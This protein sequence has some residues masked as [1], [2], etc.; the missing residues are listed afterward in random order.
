MLQD[1]VGG[2]Q[3]QV[4]GK[5]GWINAVPVPSPFVV[6]IGE[7]LEL[8]SDGYLRETVHRVVS[9]KGR[10]RLSVAFFLGARLDATVPV[11]ALPPHL[12]AE[13]P[14]PGRGS[15]SVG[16]RLRASRSACDGRHAPNLIFRQNMSA[17]GRHPRPCISSGSLDFN[18]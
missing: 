8:A 6:N 5:D 11:L 13:A 16:G 10:D 15:S 9:P 1:A 7:L 2:L 17:F 4:Q 3:V 18:V 14:R 12:A